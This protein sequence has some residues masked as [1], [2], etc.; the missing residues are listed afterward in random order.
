M[1]ESLASASDAELRGSVRELEA[2]IARL[3]YRQL[4]A[5]AELNSRNVAGALGLR[6]L[7]D[8]IMAELRASRAEARA[9]AQAVERFGARRSLTG[10]PLAPNLPA[11]AEGFATGAISSQH[12]TAI[13]AVVEAIPAPARAEHAT[14]VETTLLDFAITSDSRTVRLLGQ[15]ILAHLDPDGPAPQEQRQQQGNRRLEPVSQPGFDRVPG[16]IAHSGVPGGLGNHPR[17]AGRS[18]VLGRARR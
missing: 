2:E 8:L 6:G 16:W 14:Q 10:E 18:S 15:R 5:L 1:I 3:Q 12:A 4:A 9:K 11:T 13:A 7:P 17:A